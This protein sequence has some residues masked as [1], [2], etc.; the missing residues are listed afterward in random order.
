MNGRISSIKKNIL[1][2]LPSVDIN[3]AVIFT[4]VHSENISLPLVT[5]NALALKRVFEEIPIVIHDNEL[6]VGAPTVQPRACQ[7]FPEIQAGWLGPE[8]DKLP[9][10]EW[11]PL[12]LKQED[13]EVLEKEVLPFWK[14]KTINERV[15]RQ[16]DR[17]TKEFL[18]KDPDVYPTQPSCLIDNFSLLEKGIG[19]VV[20]NYEKILSGGVNSV[21]E[22]ITAQESNLDL[23]C[24][25]DI[26]KQVFYSAAKMTLSGLDSVDNR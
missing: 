14:G 23:T 19:T 3:R 21:I 10:R 5:R 7:V 13:K 17:K 24:P 2:T 25:V 9:T 4:Q 18:Y 1:D 26:D 6:I 11:D 16:L 15:Y 12:R 22:E 8:L 20:P